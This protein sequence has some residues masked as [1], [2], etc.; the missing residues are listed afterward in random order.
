[1][2][3]NTWWLQLDNPDGR[4]MFYL[5]VG[6]PEDGYEQLINQASALLAFPD[7]WHDRLDAGE[8]WRRALHED[9]H[10]SLFAGDVVVHGEGWAEG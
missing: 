3:V 6:Y 5:G 8:R 7:D 1:M 9:P 2:Q 10:P 4:H